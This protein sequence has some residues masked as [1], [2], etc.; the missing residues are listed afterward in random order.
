MPEKITRLSFPEF[1]H[2]HL[3]WFDGRTQS[4]IPAPIVAWNPSNVR[5]PTWG[6]RAMLQVMG[7]HTITF[8]SKRSDAERR[9]K[10]AEKFLRLFRLLELLAGRRRWNPQELAREL[11]CS[12]RELHRH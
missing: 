1:S 6:S 8:E 11:G 2:H 7:W 4:P 3:L 9:T 12:Q 10:Q 5:C